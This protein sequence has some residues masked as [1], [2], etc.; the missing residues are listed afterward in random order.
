M[1]PNITSSTRRT[2]A[3][4]RVSSNIQNVNSPNAPKASQSQVDKGK[5]ILGAK[6]STFICY[7]CGE[8]GHR[9][10]GCPKRNLCHN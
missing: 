3:I 9:F 5:G 4:G 10:A 6:P 7:K 8:L 1:V 2:Q